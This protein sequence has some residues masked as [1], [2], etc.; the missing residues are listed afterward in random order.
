MESIYYL[1]VILR[2]QE[3]NFFV[4][5]IGHIVYWSTDWSEAEKYEYRDT[6]EMIAKT[7]DGYV[8]EVECIIKV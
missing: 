6:A 4:E 7:V 5:K 1:Y 3:H 2:N 8:K